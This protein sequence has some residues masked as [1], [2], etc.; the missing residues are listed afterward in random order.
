MIWNIKLQI[1]YTYNYLVLYIK[2]DTARHIYLYSEIAAK[3]QYMF[4]NNFIF[5]LT[6]P[7]AWLALLITYCPSSVSLA[8]CL[9]ILSYFLVFYKATFPK[10]QPV[11]QRIKVLFK[12]RPMPHFDGDDNIYEKLIDFQIHSEN[13]SICSFEPKLV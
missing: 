9:Q 1:Y 8:V 3:Y 12:W 4:V 11:T 2:I 10:Y 7:K 13:H 5:H 6:Q